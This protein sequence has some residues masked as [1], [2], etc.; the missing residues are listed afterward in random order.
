[1]VSAGRHPKKEVAD[2]LGRAKAAG[3][4]VKEIHRGHRWG[5]VICPDLPG[6]PRRLLNAALSR[7]PR[8]ADRP[9]H[10]RPRPS[11][12]LIDVVYDGRR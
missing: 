6:Q 4:Q 5:E 11:V 2:A 10:S 8:K 7:H 9:L 3:L 12:R 1:V